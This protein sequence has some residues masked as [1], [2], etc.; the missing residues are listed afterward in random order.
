MSSDAGHKT[1][2][3]HTDRVTK[4][5]TDKRH[6]IGQFD[7]ELGHGFHAKYVLYDKT[8]SHSTTYRQFLQ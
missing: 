6:Q 5:Q 8:F 2:K 3:L 1:D 7:S 4:Q